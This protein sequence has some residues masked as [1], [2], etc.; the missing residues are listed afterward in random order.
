MR[1]RR[2]SHFSA[3]PLNCGVRRQIMRL[4]ALIALSISAAS[5]GVPDD[6]S[7]QR[8]RPA[9][10]TPDPDPP[11]VSDAS[12][13]SGRIASVV[14][15]FTITVEGTTKDI[16]VV[17]S[18]DPVFNQAAVDALAKWR[19]SPKIEDGQPVE[20]RGVKTRIVFQ[21]EE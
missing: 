7:A 3:R 1:S 14:L 21:L 9:Q 6:A 18:S 8:N 10:S 13:D 11:A 2:A 5:I 4:A 20:R 12:E 16:V 19:Y 15:E 17:E